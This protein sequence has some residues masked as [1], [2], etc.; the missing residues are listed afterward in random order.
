MGGTWRERSNRIGSNH[1]VTIEKNCGRDTPV[2]TALNWSESKRLSSPTRNELSNRLPLTPQNQADSG[3]E[4]GRGGLLPDRARSCGGSPSHPGGGRTAQFHPD[5][6]QSAGES[7]EKR[8]GH[9]HQ[10]MQ[11]HCGRHR[12]CN[13]HNFHRGFIQRFCSQCYDSCDLRRWFSDLSN[14]S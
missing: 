8:I 6:S 5:H 12:H 3:Q 4:T 2:I 11:C 9:C 1:N 10:G 13:L 7:R 14:D